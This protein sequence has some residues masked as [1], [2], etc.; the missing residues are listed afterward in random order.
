MQVKTWLLILLFFATASCM[1]READMEL[2]PGDNFETEADGKSIGLYTLKNANGLVTQ[3][4]NFGGKI[5][6]L[7]VPDNN[8]DLADIVLGY[9]TIEA[10]FNSGEEYFG[11]LIGRYGNRIGN[12]RFQLNGA[13]Y[14]LAAN[15]GNN[16]LH[17]GIK[18]F[19]E[20]V[21]NAEQPDSQ[22]LVLT[23]MSPDMEEGYPGN[24]EVRVQYRLTDANELNIE[25][26][27]TTDKPTPV[28]LT[29]HSFFNLKGEGNGTITDHLMQINADFYTPVDSGLIPLGTL[30]PVEDTPLDFRELTAIGER[31]NDDFEQLAFGKGYDHNYVINQTDEDLDF[32]AKVV[33]PQSG[34]V[35]EVYTNEPGIQFYSGNFLNGSETGKS[36]N[37][38][39]FR[40]AFC[41]ETQHFPNSPNQEN[42][43][44][45]LLNPGDEYYSVCVYRFGTEK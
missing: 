22:T 8:G 1:Q 43:P 4:T 25:Y 38:Y 45:T 17:G 13:T 23:Y 39:R 16:H 32:A 44:S 2:I 31:I 14:T 18:G 26:W 33:E 29:S 36:G 5:V 24:L 19:N 3:I 27:A 7:W 6:S 11:A 28:N 40:D 10:Y 12:A 37:P 20:V 30:D 15:D 35:L 34:R 21:W 41:L 42:F 9:N